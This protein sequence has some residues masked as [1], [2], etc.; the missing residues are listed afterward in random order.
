MYDMAPKNLCQLFREGRLSMN[1]ELYTIG[2]S[3]HPFGFFLELLGMHGVTAVADVRS[4][5][6]S[7]FNPQYNRETRKKS[8]EVAGIAYV[9]L[10][11]ELGPRGHKPS[12]YVEGRSPYPFIAQTELFREGLERLRRGMEKHRVAMMC[13]EKD[14]VTCHRMILI[15]RALRREHITIRHILEDGRLES[16]AVSERRLVKTLKLE[17]MELFETSDDLV[18][19]AYDMQGQR[20]V[21]RSGYSP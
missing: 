16:L 10:G 8:L 3:T 18:E 2:H 17:Q 11:R 1:T 21:T 13:A 9:W 4:V 19:R 15:C 6:Y 5:P 14:P 7:R 12:C 20:L